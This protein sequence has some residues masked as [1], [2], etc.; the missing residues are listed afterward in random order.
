MKSLTRVGKVEIAVKARERQAAKDRFQRA[1]AQY[2]SMTSA[3][4]EKLIDR[5]FSTPEDELEGF[6][7]GTSD[8]EHIA[9]HRHTEAFLKKI[10]WDAIPQEI[11][12][13][14]L[15]REFSILELKKLYPKN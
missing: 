9:L 13:K 4:I 11:S 7:A 6:V 10:D 15:R 12:Q 1:E 5:F 2:Y 14:V 8:G 3:D